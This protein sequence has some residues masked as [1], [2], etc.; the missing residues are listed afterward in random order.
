M[1]DHR[2]VS[3]EEWI[4][5]R[6]ALLAKEKEFTRQRDALSAERRAL[7][8]MRMEKDYRLQTA[9]GERSLADLFDGRS[10]L[11]V[12]HFMFGPD[13]ESPCKSCSFWADNFNGIDAHLAARDVSFLAISRA[14]LDKLQAVAKRLG[15]SF[16]WASSLGSDFNF[17][18]GVSF[19]PEEVASGEFTYNFGPHKAYGE[20]MP[21]ISVFY[22]DADGTIY[23]TYSCYARG[24]DMLNGAY[25]Y[26]DLV[27]KGRDEE[28]L[29]FTMAWLRLHDE[30]GRDEAAA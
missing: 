6:K 9:N 14:P 16:R 19:T 22:K 10:Q 7:P 1:T 17:D 12:Y 11:L 8:W 3:E 5:A 25:H 21:G 24:L 29:P 20:E 23:R 26:L 13:W 4:E 2:I 15:W 28:S 27:P 18:L 30:Y